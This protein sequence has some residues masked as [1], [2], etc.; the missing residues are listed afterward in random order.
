MHD[1]TI[2]RRL[3]AMAPRRHSTLDVPDILG[4]AKSV[5]YKVSNVLE[6]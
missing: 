3:A 1:V 4:A 2:T 6:K 5:N